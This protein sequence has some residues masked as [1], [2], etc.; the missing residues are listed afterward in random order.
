M[1][2]LAKLSDEGRGITSNPILAL[3][4]QQLAHEFG[5]DSDDETWNA[6]RANLSDDDAEIVGIKGRLIRYRLY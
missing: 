3:A 4:Y 6:Y 2:W 5:L 1:Q